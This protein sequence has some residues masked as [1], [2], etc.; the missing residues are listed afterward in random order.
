MQKISRDEFLENL[1]KVGFYYQ[2]I[3]HYI[4]ES[5]P[6]DMQFSYSAIDCNQDIFIRIFE[7]FVEHPEKFTD[8]N[9]KY[10]SNFQKLVADSV[11]K[12][13]GKEK[14]TE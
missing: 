4:L 6:E 13:I 9:I 14:K 10:V 3:L 1:R 5:K 2:E 12:F 11:E 7:Q 8:L